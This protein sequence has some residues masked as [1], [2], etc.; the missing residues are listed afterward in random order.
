MVINKN[1]FKEKIDS[2]LLEDESNRMTK[3]DSSLIFEPDVLVGFVS[4]KD[5]IFDEYKKIIGKFHLTP[6][7]AFTKYCEKNGFSSSTDN[8]TVVAFIL[9]LNKE[10]KKENL[11]Y[12]TEWPSERWANTR[13]FGEEASQKLQAYLIKELEKEGIKAVA[14]MSEKYMFKVKRKHENGVW[15]STWSLRH[16]AFAA[17][18]GS[19]GLS[20]G[21]INEKGIAMRCGSIIVGY[22]LPSDAN[23]RPSNP[24]EYCNNCGKCIE[25]CPVEAISFENRH[26]KQKC[27]TKVMGAI[28]YIKE[29]YGINIYSCGLCQV[30]VPCENGFP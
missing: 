13:L 19:F 7:E 25:R 20:D 21:F 22:K 29:N 27:S 12:S 8:L 10:T 26:D 17:G 1:W 5:S 23:K 18:L 4:G 14:P 28:P 11:N 9:P 6:S 15:A 24:Y 2:F 3:V 30:G 16:S